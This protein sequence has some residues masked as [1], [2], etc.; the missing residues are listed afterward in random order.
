MSSFKIEFDRNQMNEVK[1]ALSGVKNGKE[2]VFSRAV[3][4]TMTGVRTDA[5]KEIGA[6]LNLKAKDI[7]DSF[8]IKK[9]SVSIMDGRIDSRGKP[10]GLIHFSGTRQTQKGVSV[11]V[12]KDSA[13]KVIPHAFIA[14]AKSA[15]NV[16]WR[17]YKGPR[18]KPRIG[19]AYGKL[20]QKYR[21]PIKRLTGPRIQDIYANPEV[22][23]RVT[24]KA[25]SRLKT[26]LDRE[27][28]YELSK[29]K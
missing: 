22:F 12:R 19:F 15:E 8:S 2:K 4:S 17:T 3:N 5:T 28:N 23:E 26:N 6:V 9:A 25:D 11:K 21:F 27:L 13:R 24:E 14:T 7:R 10:I 29:L 20:P 16:F 1:K 18:A